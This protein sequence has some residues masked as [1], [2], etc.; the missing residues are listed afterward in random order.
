MARFRGCSEW[1][2]HLHGSRHGSLWQPVEMERWGERASVCV[3]DE[4]QASMTGELLLPHDEGDDEGEN[5]NEQER[6]TPSF[7]RR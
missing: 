4:E 2:G 3:Q 7:A 5:Q 1:T 6:T